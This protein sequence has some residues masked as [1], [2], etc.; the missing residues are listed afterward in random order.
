MSLFVEA[1]NTEQ[2]REKGTRIETNNLLSQTRKQECLRFG[3][4]INSHMCD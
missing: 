3:I 1:L 2:A 4:H